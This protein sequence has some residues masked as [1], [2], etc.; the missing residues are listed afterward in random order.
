ME[1]QYRFDGEPE[2]REFTCDDH[3]YMN[4]IAKQMANGDP[5]CE[6]CSYEIVRLCDYTHNFYNSN[7][8][9]N[10]YNIKEKREEEEKKNKVIKKYIKCI[11]K[12][13]I[14]LKRVYP[15]WKLLHIKVKKNPYI[16]EFKI[17]FHSYD[18]EG[19]EGIYE[20]DA[21]VRVETCFGEDEVEELNRL[22]P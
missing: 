13:I 17:S 9:D 7:V 5:R 11:C 1:Q 19:A 18:L 12:F 2:E 16:P 22:Y 14:S 20:D 10:N 15:A 21:Y 3:F 8:F 4:N 6:L